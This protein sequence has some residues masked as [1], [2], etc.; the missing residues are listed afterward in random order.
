MSKDK[1]KSVLFA[2]GAFCVSAVF[3]TVIQVPFD[4][5]FFAWVALVP[6]ILVCSPKARPWRLVWISYLVSLIYWLG[7]LY[8]IA[9][10]TVPAYILFCMYLGLY[11]PLLALCVRYCR[12]KAAVPL[13]LVVPILFLGAEAWQGILLTGFNWRLLAHSQYANLSIIQIADIFGAGGVSFIIAMVNGLAAGLLTDVFG[14]KLFRPGNIFKTVLVFLVLLSTIFYGRWRIGQTEEYTRGGPLAGSVQ[15]NVPSHVKELAEAGDEILAELLVRSDACIEAGAKLVAWPETI[16][17]TTLN[18]DYLGLCP[19]DSTPRVFDKIISGHTKE[20]AYVLLGAHAATIGV[21]DGEY[22]VVDRFNSAYLY[23]PDGS[24]GPRRYDKIHLVPF[25]E[26][27]PFRESMP[28]IAELVVKL[29]PYDYDYHLTHG[30]D[31]TIF[32]MSDGQADYRFGVLICYEDTDPVVTRKMVGVDGYKR[33]DWL[34]N[35]SNDGWYVR[36][37]DGEILP[38]VELGQRTAISVFRCVENRISILRSVNTGISC[39]IDSVGRIKDGF[40]AGD[41][42]VAAMER[43]GVGGWFVDRIWID[44]RVTIFSRRGRYLDFSFATVFVVVI[45]L[46]L[47][48]IFKGRKA[49]GSR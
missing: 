15:P 25:G 36:F 22:V 8:W 6:F 21:R 48:H 24:Q 13:F 12:K 3:L 2:F 32:E 45:I 5:H 49:G 19:E 30:R 37:R 14:R 9:I 35:I 1:P 41:L 11:W 17:L 33:L 18:K 23:G 27:I 10:V 7:N 38:S 39:L 26:Y 34:V 44:D 20:R 40:L 4:L 46:T 47:R 29:S 42:P 43:E 28:L 16:V 31:Y